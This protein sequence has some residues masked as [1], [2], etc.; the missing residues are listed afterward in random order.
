MKQDD[1]VRTAHDN[2]TLEKLKDLEKEVMSRNE[3]P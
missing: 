2:N 3:I 1:G